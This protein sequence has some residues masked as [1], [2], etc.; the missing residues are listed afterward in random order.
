MM[1]SRTA[2]CPHFQSCTA[3]A[4]PSQDY[5]KAHTLTLSNLQGT[6]WLPALCWERRPS[7]RNHAFWR[8][9]S[10]TPENFWSLG[11]YTEAWSGTIRTINLNLLK[12]CNLQQ[13][14]TSC[15]RNSSYLG[16]ITLLKQI[17]DSLQHTLTALLHLQAPQSHRGRRIGW[18]CHDSWAVYQLHILCDVHLLHHSDE[19]LGGKKMMMLNKREG[20]RNVFTTNIHLNY[21]F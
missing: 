19:L 14:N 13:P 4:H 7:A 5:I 20:Q 16:L 15:E 2:F 17:P 9:G 1:K 8:K 21:N 18:R 12:M 3:A 10:E 11:R 6:W